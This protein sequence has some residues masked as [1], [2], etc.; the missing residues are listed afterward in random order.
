M[1]E[2]ILSSGNTKVENLGETSMLN[3]AL[4]S[5]HNLLTSNKNI[6]LDLIN[7]TIDQFMKDI[8]FYKIKNNIFTD[9]SLENFFI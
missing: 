2:A 9:K 8:K 4:L 7:N 3:G 6:N 5:T 1:V